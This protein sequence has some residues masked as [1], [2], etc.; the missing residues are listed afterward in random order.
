MILV[1][2]LSSICLILAEPCTRVPVHVRLLLLLLLALL[3]VV[4]V[5]GVSPNGSRILAKHIWT[6]LP[7]PCPHTSSAAAAGGAADAMEVDGLGADAGLSA[8]VAAGPYCLAD[9]LAFDPLHE[10]L[11]ELKANPPHMLVSSG[12]RSFKGAC[13]RFK[14]CT[15]GIFFLTGPWLPVGY[16]VCG[17]CLVWLRVWLPATAPGLRLGGRLANPLA[18]ANPL[19]S[20]FNWRQERLH[21]HFLA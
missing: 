10:M 5:K 4:A 11:Q 20:G 17:A 12:T 18:L 2:Q 13:M 8:V 7:P 1:Q 21:T 9:D 15:A 14:H 19:V 3:Q 6:H 16:G